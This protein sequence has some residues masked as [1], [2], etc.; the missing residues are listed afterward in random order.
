MSEAKERLEKAKNVRRAAKGKLTRIIRTANVLLGAGRPV[1]E[2]EDIL[3]EIKDSYAAL[4]VKHEEYA[5]NN[6][7]E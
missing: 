3:K 6:V 5:I 4:I 7:F 1:Q 2:I